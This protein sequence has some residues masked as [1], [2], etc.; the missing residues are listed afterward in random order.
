MQSPTILLTGASGNYGGKVLQFL[1]KKTKACEIAALAR[2]PK[3]LA[4]QAEQGVVIRHGDYHDYESLVS[5]FTGIETLL[6]VSAEAFTERQAQEANAISAAKAAGVKHI[7]YTSIQKKPGTTEKIPMVTETN[8][9]SEAAIL[10]SG[11]QHTILRNSLYAEA[12]LNFIGDTYLKTGIIAMPGGTGRAALASSTDMAEGT[13]NL[14]LRSQPRSSTYTIGSSESFSMADV[15]SVLSEIHGKKIEYV[16][17]SPEEFIKTGTAKGAP[18][19]VLE[20]VAAWLMAIERGE[21]SEVTKDLEN[22]L[23]R[24]PE[25]IRDVIASSFP[26]HPVRAAGS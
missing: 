16:R 18:I 26:D 3:S 1:L 8:D 14:L 20:F 25:S 21:F 6:L 9:I 11:M 4:A 23:G 2:D 5:A 17:I 22:I 12:I 24:K 19:H 13:A 10:K 7:L 15:A